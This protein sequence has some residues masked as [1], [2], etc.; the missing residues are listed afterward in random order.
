MSIRVLIVDDHEVVRSGLKS[1]LE[2]A[3]FEVCGVASTLKDLVSKVEQLRPDVLLLD[4]RLGDENG[5]EVVPAVRAFNPPVNVLLFSAHDNPSHEARAYADGANGY[6][7]KSA[8]LESLLDSIR[9]AA[10]GE[11][12]WQRTDQRRLNNFVKA[13]KPP[14]GEHAPLTPREQEI[15]KI[16]ATGATNKQISQD[17]GIS[18]ET[19]KEHVQH[20][21]R[22]IGVTDRT[23]AAV[24]AARNDLL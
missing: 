18:A 23:Q 9:R 19:V 5:L 14:V 21:L 24:W 8:D 3:G 4:V 12:L 16:L 13:S 15:L 1:I 11:S 2:T 10:A 22:K 17:L 20:L 7:Y 6:L